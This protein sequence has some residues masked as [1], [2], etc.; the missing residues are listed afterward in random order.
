MLAGVVNAPNRYSPYKNEERAK[1]RRA[2]VL[3][4]MV[5][6]NY[7]TKDEAE[8][9][10]EEPFNLVG[11]QPNNY[12]YQ[13][14]IGYVIEEAAEK[15]KLNEDDISSLYTAGYRIYTTMDARAQKAAEAVYADDKNFPAGK[16]R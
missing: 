4:E 1:Q 15:L 8:K 13:S 11:L 9:A 16:K 10:K 7:I 2:L 14:F 5:K 12:Q 6:M 3:N